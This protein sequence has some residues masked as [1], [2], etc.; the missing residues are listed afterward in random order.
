MRTA[1][2]T[3]KNYDSAGNQSFQLLYELWNEFAFAHYYSR[4]ALSIFLRPF[5]LSFLRGR[6]YTTRL[7]MEDYRASIRFSTR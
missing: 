6:P 1:L 3:A 2:F 4:A 5:N 7:P